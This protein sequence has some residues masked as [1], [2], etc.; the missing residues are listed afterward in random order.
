MIYHKLIKAP[1]AINCVAAHGLKNQRIHDYPPAIRCFGTLKT[2]TATFRRDSLSVEHM[3]VN[4]GVAGSTPAPFALTG[5]G[6]LFKKCEI[7]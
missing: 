4:H 6:V 7:V 1:T 3:T 2:H 5:G